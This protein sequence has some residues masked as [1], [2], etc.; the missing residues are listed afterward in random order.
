M[1]GRGTANSRALG[2]VQNGASTGK[3]TE[4]SPFNGGLFMGPK[5]TKD[6][7]V[8]LICPMLEMG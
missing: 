1:G 8:L 2:V 4:T 7:L 6:R 5:R 3:W